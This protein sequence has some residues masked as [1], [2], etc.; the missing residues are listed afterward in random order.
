LK[1]LGYRLYDEEHK[2]MVGFGY[3]KSLPSVSA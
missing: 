3:L 2:Q 1:S